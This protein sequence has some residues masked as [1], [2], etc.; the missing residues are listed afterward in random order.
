LAAGLVPLKAARLVD[1]QLLEASVGSSNYIERATR[2]LKHGANVNARAKDS[3]D[4]PLYLAAR[5]GLADLVDLLLSRGADVNVANRAG[6]TPLFGAVLSKN[7]SIVNA[8]VLKGANVKAQ[9]TD[10]V[11]PLMLAAWA[12][13]TGDIATLLLSAGADTGTRSKD[14]DTALT[15]AVA[16]ETGGGELV[17]V[18]LGKGVDVNAVNNFGNTALMIAAS[19]GN[20]DLVRILLGSGADSSTSDKH[21][22]RPLF[23]A[24]AHGHAEVVRILLS[25][26]ADVNAKCALGNSIATQREGLPGPRTAA[27]QAS[28]AGSLETVRVLLENGAN[29]KDE[30]LVFPDTTLGSD[31]VALARQRG[32]LIKV[33]HAGALSQRV[34]PTYPSLARVSRIT[35]VVRFSVTITREGAVTN[36]KLINGHPLLAPAA[37]KAVKNWIYEPTT[38]DGQAVDVETTIDVNFTLSK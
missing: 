31:V 28:F 13:P 15:W 32:A 4:T 11:S 6:E 8:I 18:L 22:C 20:S 23:R 14:G 19:W 1:E 30:V 24:A 16:R 9:R 21:G 27:A 33:W 7:R 26:G 36:I 34:Q 35:G 12:D 2:L 38:I 3:G 17:R 37:E 29:V 5:N 10:G 25:H